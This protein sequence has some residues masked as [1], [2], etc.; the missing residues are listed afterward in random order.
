MVSSSASVS[1]SALLAKNPRAP[2]ERCHTILRI[3]VSW[4]GP[5]QSDAADGPPIVSRQH[6]V[7]GSA[8]IDLGIPRAALRLD[9]HAAMGAGEF[10]LDIRTPPLAL[11]HLEVQD[12]L[13]VEPFPAGSWMRS[14]VTRVLQKL[15]GHRD[16]LPSL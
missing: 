8:Q 5:P 10:R 2:G 7:Q 9:E 6:L 1:E 14:Q 4:A 15:L 16:E 13:F 3:R 12:P 11:A